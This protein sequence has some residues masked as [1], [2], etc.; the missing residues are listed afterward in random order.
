MSAHKKFTKVESGVKYLDLDAC[1]DSEP[2]VTIK[3]KGKEHEV[4]PMNVREYLAFTKEMEEMAPDA[5]IEDSHGWLRK[6]IIRRVPSLT[7]N[8]LL[9]LSMVQM[10]AIIDFVRE[11]NG[12]SEVE[13]AMEEDAKNQNPLVKATTT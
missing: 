2:S 7:D 10:S 9:E 5:S 4:V 1:L 11:V 8:D 13:Q 6:Q 12:E 3:L